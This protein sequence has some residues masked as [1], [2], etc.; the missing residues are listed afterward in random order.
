MHCLNLKLTYNCT[1]NCSFCFSSYL[2]DNVISLEGLLEAVKHGAENGCNEL[3][4]S[5]GEPT[6]LP[7]SIIKLINYAVKHGYKKYIIQTNGSGITNDPG[8]AE[9]LEKVAEEYEVCISFSVHGHSALVHDEMSQ[10]PGAFDKLMTAMKIISGKNCKIYTNTVIS[11]LNI[12]HLK[13][14]ANMLN[15]FHP[16]VMQF[17]MMH[18]SEPGTLST[19]LLESAEAI[20]GL[21]EIVN[22]NVLRTEGIPYCLMYGMEKCVGESYWPDAIDLYNKN[23]DYMPDFSQLENGMR[24][25]MND[26]CKCIMN[27]LCMGIWKEHSEEFLSG[28]IKPIC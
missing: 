14:I 18:L 5:G 21:K 10:T 13:A 17:S 11:S 12:R 16:E 23:D 15:G 22:E 6:L 7:D 24:W 25:K 19:G 8:L 20:R 4:L 26:C 27:E 9:F 1:N 28:G 2:K 3:V